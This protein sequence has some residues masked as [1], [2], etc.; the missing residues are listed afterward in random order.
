MHLD[1]SR[2][3]IAD[4]MHEFEAMLRDPDYI[5][6]EIARVQGALDSDK[7]AEAFASPSA[8]TRQTATNVRDL[9]SKRLGELE[10]LRTDRDRPQRDFGTCTNADGRPKARYVTRD[11]ARKAARETKRDKGDKGLRA[12]RCASLPLHYHVGHIPTWAQ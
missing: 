11:Q 9:L 5:D 10:A 6:T 3:Q 12:Y 4:A 1:D 8:A 2:R 7:L